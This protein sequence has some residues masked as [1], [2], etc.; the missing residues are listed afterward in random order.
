MRKKKSVT[1]REPSAVKK[2]WKWGSVLKTI[3]ATTKY[4]YLILRMVIK[5]YELAKAW[6]NN[7]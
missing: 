1:S 5:V 7:L 3:F 6:L 2:K 4:T